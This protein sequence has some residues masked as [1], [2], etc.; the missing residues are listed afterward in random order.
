MRAL[1]WRTLLTTNNYYGLSYNLPK[2][3]NR[4]F[5]NIICEL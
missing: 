4:E 3:C 2:R 5:S 1:L